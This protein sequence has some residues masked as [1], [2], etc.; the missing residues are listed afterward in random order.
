MLIDLIYI[1]WNIVDPDNYPFDT[2]QFG[3]ADS[4]NDGIVDILEDAGFKVFGPRKAGA[5]LEASKIYTK[6]FLKK[7]RLIVL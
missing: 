1:I 6:E 7:Y 3:I 4:N 2:Q 5:E